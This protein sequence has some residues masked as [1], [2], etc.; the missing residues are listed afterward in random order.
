MK[1]TVRIN[2]EKPLFPVSKE[3]YGLFYEDINR[4]GD[5]GIYP[6]ML[7]NRSFEDSLTPGG[8]VLDEGRRVYINRGDWPGAFNNGEG[9]DA[10]A[11]R[12]PETPIPGW[13]CENAKMELCAN[14]TLNTKRERSL[15]VSF[16]PGG[17]LWNIGYAGMYVEPNKEYDFYAFLK[18][19]APCTLTVSLE[20]ADGAVYASRAAEI[21]AAD[22]WQRVELSLVSQGEDCSCRAVITADRRC[23]VLFGFTSLLLRDT[24]KG[25]GLRR[26]IVEALKALS[27]AFMRFPGG[28]IVEG[29]SQET[30]TRFSATVGPVWERPSQNLMWHYRTTNG[31]GFHEFLQLCEDLDM[32]PLYVCNCGMS[33]QARVAECFDED[34]VEA[35]LQETLGALEYALGPVDS[36]YGAMRAKAGHPEPFKL[37]YLEIGNENFGPEYNKRYKKF[38]EALKAAY[39]GVT[40]IATTHVER[41]GLPAQMVD[42]HYYSGPEFFLENADKFDRYPRSGPKIFLGEYAVNGGLT[43][44]SL[45][46]AIAEAAFLTGVE[47]NQDLVRLCAYAPLFQNADYT[48]WKPNLIVFNNH[49]VYGIPSYHVLSMLGSSRGTDVLDCQVTSE[50]H[51]PVY[52]GIPS[53]L[54]ERPGLTFKNAKLNGQPVEIS[55]TVY[56]GWTEEDGEITLLHTGKPHP[57]TGQS[58]EWNRAFEKFIN[59]GGRSEA[60]LMWVAFGEGDLEEYTFEID[61]KCD[62]ENAFTLSIWNKLIDTDAGCVE[63]RDVGWNL[64]SVRRQIWRI[65][66]GDG[67]MDQRRMFDTAAPE[68]KRLDIDYSRYNT[69]KIN[70]HRGG[71]TCFLNGVPVQEKVLPLHPVLHVSASRDAD[72]VIIKLVNVSDRPEDVEIVLDRD[73]Y[74]DYEALVLTGEPGDVNSFEAPEN[75]SPKRLTLHNAAKTFPYTAPKTSLNI[76]RLKIK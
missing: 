45:E 56:G 52:T 9:M 75:V 2:T 30:A 46:C 23:E 44:A 70:A 13:Y 40:L 54:C 11:A 31:F 66:N 74:P 20:G 1:N 60:N 64:R 73:V 5:G 38:Y 18:I 15:R 67:T 37:K 34:T 21:K 65:E 71:Y 7:R 62:P 35:F 8:A 33:C 22:G 72:Q 61:I 41:D 10:W 6:E 57:L 25:H 39:P 50:L 17:R 69:Y 12:V 55:R 76:L 28:C 47:R 42:E 16:L 27:P 4:A 24:Y 36:H 29:F 32:E 51:P 14:D 19:G 26:D 59:R 48:A 3:L 49:K 43:V 63:P 53:L 58:E 68:V